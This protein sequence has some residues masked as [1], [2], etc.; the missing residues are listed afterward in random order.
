MFQNSNTVITVQCI[1]N[2]EQD[3]SRQV[4]PESPVKSI[5]GE[6]VPRKVSTA[7]QEAASGSSAAIRLALPP[8]RIRRTSE[9]HPR[10][11]HAC[12]YMCM[13]A[14]KQAVCARDVGRKKDTLHDFVVYDFTPAG[15]CLFV[16]I[17]F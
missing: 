6:P 5:L 3:G 11:V 9:P 17:F 14:H 7:S 4:S 10:S 16:F 2:T 8:S 12:V 13:H 15:V 1:T